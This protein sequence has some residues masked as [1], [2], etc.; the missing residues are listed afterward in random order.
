MVDL[1]IRGGRVVD[2]RARTAEA[3]D[4]LV[5]ADTIV[6]VGPPGTAAPAEAR[7]VDARGRLLIP[8]LVNAH[9]H[10]HSN[11]A[12]G[13]VDRYDLQLLLNAAGW[14]SG[15]RTVEDKYLSTLIGAVEMVKKGVTAAYDLS[16]E[17]PA[18]SVEGLEAMARAY[19]D[20]GMRAAVAPMMADRTFHQAIPG[21]LES[22]P[23]DLR[24]RV[25]GVTMAPYT[26]SLE[27]CRKIL[28]SWKHD[29]EQVRPAL[30]P[31]IPLHCSDPFM[32]GCRD[33]AREF[34]VGIHMH[35]AE[36][37]L[38]AIA[39]V[40]RY[41][42]TLVG[43]LDR[44]ELLG[45]QF[46]AAHAIWLDRDDMT[47]LGDHGASAAH[48]PG[49]NMRLGSG[50]AAIRAMRAQGVNV[51]IGTDGT[52]C[53]DN[54][55]V[56]E[57]MRLASF[58]SRVQGTP[59]EQWLTASDV[60]TMATEGGARAL[61]FERLGRIAPG[62]RADL[63]FLDAGHPNYVPL[64]DPVNQIVYAEDATAVHSVMI[65]GRLVVDAGRVTTVDVAALAARAAAA[66]E[67]LRGANEP[68][69][70]LVEALEPVIGAICGTLMTRPY[71]VE[72]HATQAGLA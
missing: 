25:A 63:V 16:F 61:G 1:V 31:T 72:R 60:L 9:T 57:A 2:A 46:T 45:P 10:G 17:L 27:T 66:V 29:P 15:N 20:V 53:S 24:E 54:Q 21:L 37:R 26:A 38:Q 59:P 3:A 28:Q 18:P 8:G 34:G 56:F 43:H 65:G 4:V 67:R 51:A 12:K 50:L 11:L 58:V 36:S 70:R 39:G 33:L 69:R 52:S 6:A 40:Q 64:N 68:A 42:T 32:V 5:E 44:L 14:F 13:M 35:V 30:A 22:L 62:Y 47:R 71:H 49:S 7:T 55:N 41:G 19:A 23:A 48:N